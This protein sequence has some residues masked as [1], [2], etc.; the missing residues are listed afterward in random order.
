MDR[1]H[2]TLITAW[3]ILGVGNHCRDVEK[4]VNFYY[5]FLSL[6]FKSFWNDIRLILV[7]RQ[8]LKAQSCPP[9]IQCK[10]NRRESGSAV[11]LLYMNTKYSYYSL[12]CTLSCNGVTHRKYTPKIR[13]HR[14][15]CFLAWAFYSLYR[16]PSVVKVFAKQIIQINY[17]YIYT[18]YIHKRIMVGC[19]HVS[20]FYIHTI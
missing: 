17:K 15:F 16:M 10:D 5:H 2:R 6:E 12:I 20:P 19:T 11:V 8:V 7:Y 14:T 4:N 18:R 13:M 9:E 3:M 1:D